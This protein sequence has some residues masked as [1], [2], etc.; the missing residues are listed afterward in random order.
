MNP[1]EFQIAEAKDLSNIRT[2]TQGGALGGVTM[3]Y[4]AFEYKGVTTKVHTFMTNG[5]YSK[6]SEEVL[7]EISKADM[8]V[9]MLNRLKG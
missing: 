3:V 7:E 5:S 8:Y 6:T 4:F 9:D 1:K 2:G